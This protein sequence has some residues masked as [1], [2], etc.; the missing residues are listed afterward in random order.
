[1]SLR[2]LDGPS[3]SRLEKLTEHIAGEINE[4][5]AKMTPE[6]SVRTDAE[7]RRIAALL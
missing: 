1:M 7:T 5:A 6:Q 4:R 3:E 2:R